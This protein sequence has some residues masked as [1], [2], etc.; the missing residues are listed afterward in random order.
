MS[1][2]PLLRICCILRL[3]ISTY[4]AKE[5]YDSFNVNVFGVLNVTRAVLPYMRQQRSGV[6]AQFGSLG[7]WRGVPAGGI[8]CAT[9][10]AVTGL[11]ESLRAEVAPFGIEVCCIEPG[12][13]RT[14]FLNP[15]AR[16]Q[17]ETRLK[18]YDDTT[19]GKI[20]AMFEERDN[21]QPGDT[22]KGVKVMFDVLTKKHGNEVPIRL[23]LGSDCYQGIEAKCDE[24]KALLHEWKNVICS[25]DHDD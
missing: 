19:V 12:Y 10:W 6:I 18:D 13:F 7:S 22:E 4:S 5:T 2:D 20:R 14:G 16:M 17:T 21:K 25:T 8:Y 9:K 1:C 3:T 24:T 11:T 15:G 23:V